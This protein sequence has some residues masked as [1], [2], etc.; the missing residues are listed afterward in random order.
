MHMQSNSLL[1]STQAGF[2]KQKDTMYQL[3]NVIMALEDAK[4]SHKDIYALIVD[5]IFAFNTTD[6]DC[7]LMI[8]YDLGF[9]TDAIKTV[10]NLY[11]GANTQIYLP[12]GGSTSP[13]PVERGTIQGDTLS[14]FLF[15]PYM[16]P[17]LRWLHVG[18]KGYNH[19]CLE[20]QRLAGNIAAIKDTHLDNSLSNGAFADDLLC[21]TSS[22][23]N[24]CIQAEKLTRYSDWAA[25]QAS[26]SKTKVT[27][28][29]HGAARTGTYGQD[30]SKHLQTQLSGKIEVQGQH[31][32]FVKQDETFLYLDVELTMSLN[33]EHQHKRMTENLKAKL[34]GV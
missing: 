4:A 2:Q 33:W 6:H 18:V 11:Q 23:S 20:P 9:P 28:I 34:A 7:M 5:F 19:G 27:G 31:A 8:M 29:L 10:K 3:Q 22:L 30:P 24:L 13:I 16:E 32:Q 1:S 15:L 26:G 14:P 12:F 25:L 21:L 17:L